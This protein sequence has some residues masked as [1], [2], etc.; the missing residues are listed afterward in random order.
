MHLELR[1]INLVIE[2]FGSPFWHQVLFELSVVAFSLTR[3]L[4]GSLHM[5]LT[6]QISL[7]VEQRL[8]RPGKSIAEGWKKRGR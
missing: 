5:R 1:R 2:V 3:S 7:L 6:L 8:Q 4:R